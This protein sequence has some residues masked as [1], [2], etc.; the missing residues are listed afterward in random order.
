MEHSGRVS[1]RK[2]TMLKK[3]EGKPH[4]QRHGRGL[5]ENAFA[6]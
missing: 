2:Q 1:Q 6:T 5:K 3:K 4:Q